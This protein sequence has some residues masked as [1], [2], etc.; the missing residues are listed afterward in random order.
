[1]VGALSAVS[2]TAA[3]APVT[4]FR[5]HYTVGGFVSLGI[6]AVTLVVVWWLLNVIT[7]YNDN[8]EMFVNNNVGYA[9]VRTLQIVAVGYAISPVVG[10]TTD[11]W[12]QQAVW[13]LVDAAWVVVLLLIVARMLTVLVE[14]AH[15]GINAIR[16][17]NAQ[18][19]LVTGMVYVA[20]GLVM[21]TTLPGP[22]SLGVG[23]TFVVSSVFGL[24]GM[25]FVLAVYLVF[26]RV[27]VFRDHFRMDG[28]EPTSYKY[29][30]GAAIADGNWA[31]TVLAATLM[32]S[33]GVVT[34]SAVAGDFT[35]WADSI[36]TFLIAALIMVALTSV[37]MWTT[38]RF[39]ITRDTTRSMIEKSLWV[40]ALAMSDSCSRSRWQ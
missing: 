35:G 4:P 11:Q 6:V 23:M 19:G 8:E 13:A 38:D 14:Q 39:V 33:F 5:G 21:G 7:K 25:A 40:P 34:S 20:F 28:S 12:W 22:S 3:S 1:M 2:Q 17:C 10:Y 37:A 29:S 16:H 36:V 30:L 26:S 32:F 27:R 9:V 18:V 31:A 15:G 24:L